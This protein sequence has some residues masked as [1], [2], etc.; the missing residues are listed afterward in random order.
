MDSRRAEQAADQHHELQLQ[1]PPR[2]EPVQLRL[3]ELLPEGQVLRFDDDQLIQHFPGI[4]I[5][6]LP[7]RLVQREIE[8]LIQDQRLRQRRVV[9]EGGCHRRAVEGVAGL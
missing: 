4:L 3:E 9:L 7:Q 6:D 1:A 5:A 2:V 8:Q